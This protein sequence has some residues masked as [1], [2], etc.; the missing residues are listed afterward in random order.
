MAPIS[1][2]G[3]IS[4]GL[5]LWHWPWA[6]W[7]L[8]PT[9]GFEPARA[10]L[11]VTLTILT[12]S[13]SYHL[14]EMPIREGTISKFLTETKTIV[15][16]VTAMLIVAL[17]AGATGGTPISKSIFNILYGSSLDDKTIMV[18]GDSVP[19]R[20]M[21]SLTKQASERGYSVVSAARGA[22]SPMGLDLIYEPSNPSHSDCPA[23]LPTQEETRESY[24]PGHILWW[25]RYEIIDRYQGD[26]ILSPDTEQ[27]WVAQD[28]DF[29]A[30]VDR[31][32]RDGSTLT[33][34]LTER[35]GLGT[36]D[37]PE[38]E[39]KAPI[40]KYMI[41]HDE[42]RQR[43]NEIVRAVSRDNDRVFVVDGDTMFCGSE[44]TG[45]SDS[46]CD[47]SVD[48]KFIRYD[49]SHIDMEPFGDLI[50][51]RLLDRFDDSTARRR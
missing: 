22:C 21:P 37:R 12:A 32:T 28:Q 13:A 51:E 49:G 20:L 15:F 6:I 27:F 34:V 36:L 11:V 46:L 30:S 23:I 2:L 24:R 7:L 25:S 26:K 45:R 16:G 35:P 5:Y 33:V 42:Y 18:V 44:P 39:L 31:L 50:S 41:N 1:Y 3:R 19:L 8:T 14:L 40:I 9:K 4:Y 47:D 29:R 10:L 17:F 43:F 38:S 48:G